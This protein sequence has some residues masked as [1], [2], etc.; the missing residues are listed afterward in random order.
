MTTTSMASMATT[1][2][3]VNLVCDARP[4]NGDLVLK[5]RPKAHHDDPIRAR[6]SA[7]LQAGIDG[8]KLSRYE[9]AVSNRENEAEPSR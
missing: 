6:H 8:F 5:G 7:M 9:H 4:L 1:C 3:G 2:P